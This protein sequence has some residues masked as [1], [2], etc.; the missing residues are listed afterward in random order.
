M[1]SAPTAQRVE[2]SPATFQPSPAEHARIAQ[3][4]ASSGARI[5]TDDAREG[6]VQRALDGEPA[7]TA[8]PAPA[9]PA[10]TGATPPGGASTALGA[11]DQPQQLEHLL[12]RLYPPLVRRLKAE[13]LVDRERRGVRIDRI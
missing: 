3:V 13:M 1:V 2:A 6:V 4:L 5:A 10:A 11:V 12:D 8:P 7:G 9:T